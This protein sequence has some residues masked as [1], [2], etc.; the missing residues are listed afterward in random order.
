MTDDE[1]RRIDVQWKSDVDKK[2]DKL[3]KFMELMT[4]RET[5]LTESVDELTAVLTNGRGALN[6]LY[7]LAKITAACGVL[8]AALYAFKEW[9]LK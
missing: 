4:I 7:L 3:V 5:T 6:F 1:R 9:I 2:L 8:L